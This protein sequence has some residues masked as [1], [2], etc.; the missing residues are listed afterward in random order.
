VSLNEIWFALFIVIIA[1]YVILDGFDLGV[2]IL[3]LF[4]GTNDEERR[5]LLNSIG[6]IWD[7]NEVWLVVGGGVLFA[8]FPMVY[9][10]MFS[11]F[12]W[13]LMLVLL[14]MILRTVAIE[15]RSKRE[16]R[17]WRGRWDAVFSVSSYALAFLLGV[18]LGNVVA[19]VPLTSSG[20]IQISSVFDLLKLFPDLVG[21]TAIAMLALHGGLYVEVK[22]AGD[23]YTRVRTWLPWIAVVF[24]VLGV[25]VVVF[26]VAR[27][28]TVV[29][30]YKGSPWLVIFPLAAGAAFGGIWFFRRSGR[31][32]AAFFSSCAMLALLMISAGI[33]MYPNLLP[34]TTDPAYSMTVTNSASA[35]ETLTVMLIVAI[36]GFPFVLLY[37]AGVQFLFRGK[38]T[39]SADSY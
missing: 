31:D 39:L 32:V 23:I 11:G 15:F 22:T 18:A 9:A 10:A 34:S 25:T 33:G 36:I 2:G 38:V 5:L 12:Y 35:S 17:S 21:L 27:D 16:K 37:T 19:G 28:Y 30:P 24:V 13:A 6:P 14:F 26:T 20:D 29:Q 1:G 8:A 3:H 7:G 4:A